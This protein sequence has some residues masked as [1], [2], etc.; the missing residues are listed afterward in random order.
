MHISD[1]VVAEKLVDPLHALA[2]DGRAQVT[3]VERLG[4]IRSAIIYNNGLWH[5]LL[6]HTKRRLTPH[7]RQVTLQKSARYSQIN[8]TRHNGSHRLKVFVM[9]LLG[10]GLGNLNGGLVIDLGSCQSA[11]ALVFAQIRP[12]GNGHPAVGTV[13]SGGFK[14]IRHFTGNQIQNFFHGVFLTCCF[15]TFYYTKYRRKSTEK[16]QKN[17]RVVRAA[18]QKPVRSANSAAGTA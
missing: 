3:N 17:R 1:G 18:T 15:R 9:Q 7:G 2:N 13:K 10:Y 11:I 4:D 14:G 6:F 8:E 5:R 16:I 12:I